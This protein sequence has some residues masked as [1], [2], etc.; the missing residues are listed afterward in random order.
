MQHLSLA[1]IQEKAPKHHSYLNYSVSWFHF[2]A[3]LKSILVLLKSDASY[4]ATQ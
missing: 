2:I 3:F 1:V 4:Y